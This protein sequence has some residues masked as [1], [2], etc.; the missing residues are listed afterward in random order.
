MHSTQPTYTATMQSNYQNTTPNKQLPNGS[1]SSMIV[2]PT[3]STG[4]SFSFQDVAVELDSLYDLTDP[5]V[6]TTTDH[7]SSYA[8]PNEMAVANRSPLPL[9][10]LFSP[11]VHLHPA[12]PRYHAN[13]QHCARC[14]TMINSYCRILPPTTPNGQQQWVCALCQKQQPFRSEIN[15]FIQPMPLQTA[16]GAPTP[17]SAP[18]PAEVALRVIETVTPSSANAA[19]LPP[20]VFP[21]SIRGVDVG[22]PRSTG[23]GLNYIFLIDRTIPKSD[24]A[25]LKRRLTSVVKSLPPDAG[26]ALLTFS[27][28]VT[29][30]D[31][32]QVGVAATSVLAGDSSP[33]IEALEEFIQE[34]GILLTRVSKAVD[35]FLDCMESLEQSSTT[36]DQQKLL[37]PRAMGPAVEWSTAIVQAGRE[38]DRIA[39]SSPSSSSS[40]RIGSFCFTQLVVLT[41]GPPDFGPGETTFEVDTHENRLA[42]QYYTDLGERARSSHLQIDYLTHGMGNFSVPIVRKLVS[43][44][45]GSVYMH[46]CFDETFESDLRGCLYRAIGYDGRVEINFSS[47]IKIMRVIGGV[48]QI[49]TDVQLAPTTTATQTPNTNSD[50]TP[51][52]E[53]EKNGSESVSHIRLHLANC[54][55][56]ESIAIY[57]GLKEDLPQ[58][59]VFIQSVFT[60]TDWN[61]QT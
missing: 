6:A 40:S 13:L 21:A 52:D 49:E 53:D 15:Q 33:T 19:I 8:I 14:Q 38:Y 22:H 61:H 28:T 58:D 24:F 23:A 11:A 47:G 48:A 25:D 56:D 34:R 42:K 18:M 2:P 39:A 12:P 35:T 36:V 60:Y 27:N 32:S 10:M 1:Y 29:I 4:G 3:P 46:K 45:G 5:T 7:L 16:D 17:I 20:S 26:L 43:P 44:T 41:S 37:N 9:G 50:E 55:P 51:N 57:Y 30:Y 59:Y 54:R 31:L